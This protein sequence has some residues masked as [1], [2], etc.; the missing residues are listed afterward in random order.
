MNKRFTLQRF[1]ALVTIES[2]ASLAWLFLIS[3][4][5]TSSLLVG[6]SKSHLTIFLIL[7]LVFVLS[8]IA[9]YQGYTN[10]TWSREFAQKIGFYLQTRVGLIITTLIRIGLVI[11]IYLFAAMLTAPSQDIRDY[12][13]RLAPGISWFIA[14]SI[15]M[16]VYVHFHQEDNSR[17]LSGEF[18]CYVFL[19]LALSFAVFKLT[20]YSISHYEDL[21]EAV[22][23][24]ITRRPHWRAYS[25]RLLGPYLVYFI[26]IFG[27][28]FDKAL[29]IFNFLMLS[30]QNLALFTLLSLYW[31]TSYRGAFRYVIYFSFLFIILQDKYSYPWDYI[32]LVVFTFFVWG[33]F[34]KNSL[35]Y[36]VFLFLVELLN[37]ET[38]LFIPLYL[39]IDSVKFISNEHSFFPHLSH[40][41]KSKTNFWVG[42]FLLAGGAI[43][44]KIIRNMLFIESSLT[45][46]GKDMENKL[47]G[48]HNHLIDNIKDLFFYNF[49]SL[50]SVN[51]LFIFGFIIYL[52]LLFP[53]FKDRH[54]KAFSIAFMLFISILITGRV[55]ETRILMV[56]IPF[57]LFF[58]LDIGSK[59]FHH[60]WKLP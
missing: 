53:Q 55:N 40:Y 27:F 13:I 30:V 33:I 54:Y 11:G 43:Y 16:L 44:T 39:I 49:T 1:F 4:K 17:K 35:K 59:H 41:A 25:N 8:A 56:L 3:R 52:L 14:I 58:H 19:V 26:S 50:E 12:L 48:N 24:I 47:L 46:V 9:T 60:S 42:S 37:R 6:F 18:G 51:S 22:Y 23:G 7:L 20:T 57:V 10:S 28:K 31:K 38:S 21:P 2:V 45:R 15:Q 32:D 5:Y 29:E 36:F 34:H